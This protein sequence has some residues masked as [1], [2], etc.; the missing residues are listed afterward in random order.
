MA[1]A[2]LDQFFSRYVRGREELDYDA[3]LKA[4][5]LRLD[6]SGES[7]RP[8]HEA[9][10]EFFG[11]DLAQQGERLMVTKVYAGSP[12]YEQGL[13]AGDQI[14]A[15]DNMRASQKILCWR[16]WR[17][18]NRA[19][20]CDWR[21]FAS[22]ICEYSTSSWARATSGSTVSSQSPSRPTSRRRIIRRGWERRW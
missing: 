18:K 3:A 7:D 10:P 4:A 1:G 2:S 11:A 9:R 14:V 8:E 19:T 20:Q 22:M 5:G 15:F 21:S 17:R 16:A 12:A 6:T 13:N